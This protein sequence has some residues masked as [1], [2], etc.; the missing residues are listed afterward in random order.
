MPEV[1]HVQ[2]PAILH[3][4]DVELEARPTIQLAV[5]D[6]LRVTGKRSVGQVQVSSAGLRG[7]AGR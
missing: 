2:I 4:L 1:T 7:H 5:A 3:L 6:H